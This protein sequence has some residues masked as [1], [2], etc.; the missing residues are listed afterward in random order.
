[1]GFGV[2]LEKTISPC[3]NGISALRTCIVE[4]IVNCFEYLFSNFLEWNRIK[5]KTYFN[6]GNSTILHHY[7]MALE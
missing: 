5:C 2:F 3:R 7:D 6:R 1:M 4:G